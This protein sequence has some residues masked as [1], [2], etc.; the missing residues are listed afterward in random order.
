MGA[1]DRLPPLASVPFESA[2]PAA[3]GAV[4]VAVA[5]LLLWSQAGDRRLLAASLLSLVVAGVAVLADRLVITD[6]EAVENL[7]ESLARAAERGDAATILDAIDPAMLPVR[8][9]AERALREF[10]PDEV[11]ITR[12]DVTV[13]GAGPDRRA[14]ADLLVHARGALGA[15]GGPANLLVDLRVDLRHDAGRWLVADFEAREGRPGRR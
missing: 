9:E 15:G 7:F 14:R 11:R 13:E 4:A 2:W 8:L 3:I 12:C 1:T 6:R 10:R 5:C